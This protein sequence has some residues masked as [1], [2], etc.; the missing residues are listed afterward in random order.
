[1]RAWS[2]SLAACWSAALLAACG[3]SGGQAFQPRPGQHFAVK[4][5]PSAGRSL[6][7][8]ASQVTTDTLLS[9]RGA[10]LRKAEPFPPCPGEAGEQTFTLPGGDVLQ[11][12]FTV[13]NGTAKTAAY[14]RPARASDDP[15]AIDALRRVVCTSPL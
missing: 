5:T 4:Q 6:G 1:M 2:I 15:A 3:G 9:R 13:W 8:L 11:I 7:D 12:A 14:Q 10:K